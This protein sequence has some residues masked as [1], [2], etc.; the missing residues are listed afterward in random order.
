[1]KQIAHS[2]SFLKTTIAAALLGGEDP[3]CVLETAEHLKP[4]AALKNTDPKKLSACI[5]AI[6]NPNAFA[7]TN[8][9]IVLARAQRYLTGLSI[10]LN[11]TAPPSKKTPAAKKQIV[12]EV[13]PM[14]AAT[15]SQPTVAE[16]DAELLS[17][18]GIGPKS[19]AR[20]AAFGI[21]TPVEIL[22][23]LP[24]RYDDRRY[25]VPIADL[26]V[27]V[28]S[29]T[30][31]IIEKV[32][33]FGRPWKRI[34]QV[35]IK[36][37][38]ASLVGMWFS[39][40]RPNTSRF[41]KGQKLKMAGLVGQYK[42]KLQMAH[43][44]VAFDGENNNAMDRI[45]PV[46]PD[47]PGI[48]GATIEKAIQC[49]IDK[50]DRYITDPVPKKLV[51]KHGLI[52]L[53]DALRLVH[54]P[55]EEVDIKELDAWVHGSSPAHRRLA[56]DEFLFIQ[57]ALALRKMGET[58]TGAPAVKSS[59]NL[60]DRT[61]LLLGF[62][63]TGAQQRVITEIQQD[64]CRP[65]PMRRLLQGDVGSGKTMVAL[66]AI[67]ACAES[68]YQA[69]LMAP[70]E[71]LAEQHMRT[72]YPVLKKMGIRAAL[73]IGNARSSA[74]KKFIEQIRSGQIQVAIG[75]HALISESVEFSNLGL[76]VIDEQ[77]RFGVSQRLGL[78]GKAKDG[79]APHLLVMT[80][81]PIPRSL[82]LTVHGDLDVSVLDELPPGR[83]PIFTEYIPNNDRAAA[84]SHIDAALARGEQA[85]VVCPIIEESETLNVSDAENTFS[86]YEDRCGKKK[87]ALLH[88]RLSLEQ[89]ED[90]MDRFIA[91]H[92][93]ILVCTTVIEVGVNV[94]NATVMVIEGCERFG[95]AQLHQL[96][97]R[98]GRSSLASKCILLGTPSTEESQLR[99]ETMTS[100]NDG[101]YIAEQ[102][103]QIRGPG[104][105]YGKRQAGLPGFKFGNLKRDIDLLVAARQD[106]Q[107]ILTDTPKLASGGITALDGKYA[108]LSNE[109]KRR[110]LAGDGPVGEESG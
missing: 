1:M 94:P 47:I 5:N 105:L 45:V 71:I 18:K 88:G 41:V 85:Y 102:D 60:V 31:G 20:L 3:S 28:R 90:V 107:D 73:H 56:Y 66:C 23:L 29:V 70:T 83:T 25:V 99:I 95:L 9:K 49:A 69:A 68:G 21:D 24:R 103:L 96:R 11:D 13:P 72:L 53:T 14:A 50:I 34:M 12:Q 74:R 17:L 61:A 22:F 36:D 101:F 59:I 92:I 54:I 26:K 110:I 98:V 97:G 30:E 76:A 55:P 52:P 89:R 104:E 79:R 62:S 58:K 63:P 19:G 81:T 10:E 65:V 27:G 67:V 4:L 43:P 2:I 40:R 91:G 80:A 38:D 15:F 87:V 109:L 7:G 93:D 16:L 37:G 42:N 51:S 86:F 77:H 33:V 35:E 78:Q 44:N 48:P 46:Y 100:S 57:L 106:A 39:N 8:R 64:I 32:A 6:Q 108:S 82:A 84:L 75:T